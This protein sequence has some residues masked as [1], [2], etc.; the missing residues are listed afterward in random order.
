[1][2]IRHNHHI[3]LIVKQSDNFSRSA[4]SEINANVV[5]TLKSSRISIT[6]IKSSKIYVC[7]VSISLLCMRLSVSLRCMLYISLSSLYC[8]HQ[9]M[10]HICC[11]LVSLLYKI[12][13][14]FNLKRDLYSVINFLVFAF[15]SKGDMQ[16]NIAFQYYIEVQLYSYYEL[17][18][19]CKI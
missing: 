17:C 3:G 1:V 9:P 19:S 15:F 8:F 18:S 2:H 4:V 6:Y 13:Y 7:I 14:Y 12:N 10:F 16:C 5:L 11:I